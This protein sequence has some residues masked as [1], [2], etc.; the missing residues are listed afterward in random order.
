[1]DRL[2]SLS[3]AVIAL[4]MTSSGVQASE[5]G[6]TTCTVA[7]APV[8]KSVTVDEYTLQASFK[9]A[10]GAE[11]SFLPSCQTSTDKCCCKDTGD[12]PVD[13]QKAIK[14]VLGT[15]GHVS[16]G[17]EQT[18]TVTIDGLPADRGNRM[19][20]ICRDARSQKCTVTVELPKKTPTGTWSCPQ[21]QR[22]CFDSGMNSAC[23]RFHK[24]VQAACLLAILYEKPVLAAFWR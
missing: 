8:N 12:C 17:S 21:N 2:F 10:S 19:Y 6:P 22:T 7:A 18:Y 14:D 4:A 11:D 20:Y 23:T 3:C 1:M 5:A 9:C 16:K 15:K 24:M 13:D